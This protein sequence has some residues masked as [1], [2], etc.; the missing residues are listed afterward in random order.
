MGFWGEGPK[1]E[2]VQFGSNH[3]KRGYISILLVCIAHPLCWVMLWHMEKL[4]WSHHLQFWKLL[5]SSVL[6]DIGFGS[7]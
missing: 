3:T 4:S 2:A 1:E 7:C 6:L 5:I